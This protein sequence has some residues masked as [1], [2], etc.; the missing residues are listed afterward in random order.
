M[1]TQ[2]NYMT[3]DQRATDKAQELL[4]KAAYFRL[5][6]KPEQWSR[7]IERKALRKLEHSFVLRHMLD[8]RF[9]RPSVLPPSSYDY[10]PQPL[11]SPA[12][13]SPTSDGT[14]QEPNNVQS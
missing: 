11:P 1:Y 6:G 12:V 3:L 13:N 10:D 5:E 8:K 2:L 7:D 4:A 9:P 14:N